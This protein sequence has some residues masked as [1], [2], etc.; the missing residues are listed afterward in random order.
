MVF[1]VIAAFIAIVFGLVALGAISLQDLERDP[2]C[3]RST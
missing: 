3:S 2:T 1:N